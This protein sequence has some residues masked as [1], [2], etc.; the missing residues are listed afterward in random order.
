MVWMA[1]LMALAM[2]ESTPSAPPG[3][4]WSPARACVDAR[5]AQAE[6]G[7]DPGGWHECRA[8]DAFGRCP[9][10]PR[11]FDRQGAQVRCVRP[12]VSVD[13]PEIL[14]RRLFPAP[15]SAIL[16][17]IGAPAWL[18][19]CVD[20]GGRDADCGKDP[21][22]WHECW[23]ADAFGRCPEDPKCYDP[24]GVQVRCVL[25][26]FYKTPRCPDGA[27]VGSNGSCIGHRGV[28]VI[29]P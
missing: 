14:I 12:V 5:G 18:R 6:C 26:V 29:R 19:A 22:Q 4:A 16:R 17:P 1:L 28:L 9:N 21:A 27:P 10:D 7:P 23:G 20:S 2:Q 15:A 25:P 13:R 11:C 8:A 24:T 3:G